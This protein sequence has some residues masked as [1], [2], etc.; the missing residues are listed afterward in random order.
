MYSTPY[1]APN[2][3]D[4]LATQHSQRKCFAERFGLISPLVEW[5]DEMNF[6]RAA[7][8]IRHVKCQESGSNR[9]EIRHNTSQ[10]GRKKEEIY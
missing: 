10:P 8:A 5:L 4:G 6:R 1:T 7:R 9:S 2:V 3:F